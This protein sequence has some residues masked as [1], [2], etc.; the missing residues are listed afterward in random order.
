MKP[1]AFIIALSLIGL[2]FAKKPQIEY[3]NLLSCKKV[4]IPKI[5]PSGIRIIHEGGA[6]SIPIE[7]LPEDIRKDLGITLKGANAY[8]QT[9]FEEE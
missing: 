4:R 7:E 1:Q 3:E 9:I 8:R 5:L 6:T 2:S